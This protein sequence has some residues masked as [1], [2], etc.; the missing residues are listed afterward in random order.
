MTTIQGNDL[1]YIIMSEI[2]ID[3]EK[4]IISQSKLNTDS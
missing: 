1:Q 2:Q 3:P 4:L